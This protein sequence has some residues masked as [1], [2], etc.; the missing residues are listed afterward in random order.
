M[1]TATSPVTTPIV[2]RDTDALAA[3]FAT[4]LRDPTVDPRRL[5]RAAR[6]LADCERLAD[7]RW[8]C[9]ASSGKAAY[10]IIGGLCNCSDATYRDPRRCAHALAVRVVTLLE[11]AEAEA[12]DPTVDEI[13]YVLTAQAIAVL[14]PHRACAA[15]DD[16]AADHDG[17]EGQCTRHGVDAEGWWS[18][19]CRGFAVDDD[20]A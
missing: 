5:L 2:A 4:I 14:E 7:G 19:D 15:C 8:I 17:P 3:V 18:C 9:P 12:L 6:L 16:T 1:T 11:R 20:V 10:H 13:P